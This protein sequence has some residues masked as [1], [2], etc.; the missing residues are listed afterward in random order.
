MRLKII[1]SLICVILA[2]LHIAFPAFAVDYV[3]LVLLIAAGI[4]WF[5]PLIKSLELP[6]GFKIE[7]QD[8]KTATDKVSSG[9]KEREEPDTIA[10]IPNVSFEEES[11]I[12]RLR[13]L[14]YSN[15][16][17][18]LVGLRIEIEKRLAEFAQSEGISTERRTVGW[19]LRELQQRKKLSP[20]TASGLNE[21]VALGNQA[22]H[23][24]DVTRDAAEWA[25]D[26]APTIFGMIK[27]PHIAFLKVCDALYKL[28]I[29]CAGIP[30]QSQW[31]QTDFE[32]AL[33]R[34]EERQLIS[35]SERAEIDA[36]YTLGVDIRYGFGS[37]YEESMTRMPRLEQLLE[38]LKRRYERGEANAVKCNP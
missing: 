8:V 18:A 1:V 6:G 10:P 11:A 28:V 9:T 32:A 31:N 23:G 38:L 34:L 5:A 12:E 7:L 33:N 30:F 14:A 4:L 13:N 16:N 35:S 17:V 19:L 25:I 21:L 2:G 3:T 37:W 36:L 20:A 24:A 15:P 27:A 22:A 26:T 29:T